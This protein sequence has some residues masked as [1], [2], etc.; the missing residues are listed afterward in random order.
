[1]LSFDR[2]GFA[3]RTWLCASTFAN[4][5]PLH[6]QRHLAVLTTGYLK[7]PGRPVEQYSRSALLAGKLS[8]ALTGAGEEEDCVRIIE[9]ETPA[10]ILCG[11]EASVPET[12]RRAYFDLIS[13]GF[14][15]RADAASARLFLRFAGPPAHLQKFSR[16]TVRLRFSENSTDPHEVAIDLKKHPDGS[17]VT[18]LELFIERATAAKPLAYRANL[19]F[20]NGETVPVTSLFAT[21]PNMLGLLATGNDNPGFFLDIE[22]N[23]DKDAGEF[24]ADVS[25]L[26]SPG[27]AFIPHFDFNWLFSKAGGG[28]PA[29]DV[30]PAGLNQMVEVQA[31]I[32][33]V[34]PPIPIS[35][36]K[37]Q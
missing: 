25:L 17:F 26:H 5:L 10:A 3:E 21:I 35:P 28:E 23:G 24:W 14:A 33:S 29:L 13:T 30:T 7:E 11:S 2:S 36:T 8:A 27:P 16:L 15:T 37:S 34:S 4:S 6:V 1:M 20:S 18:A 9:F 12:Y 19:L 32:V 22:A 31:R